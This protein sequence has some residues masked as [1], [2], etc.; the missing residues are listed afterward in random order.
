MVR[1]R[2]YIRLV[3]RMKYRCGHLQLSYIAEAVR[4]SRLGNLGKAILLAEK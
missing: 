2:H 4:R 3:T 1:F